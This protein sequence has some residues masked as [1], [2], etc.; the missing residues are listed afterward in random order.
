[1]SSG[2]S[3]ITESIDRETTQKVAA[4]PAS[5]DQESE[6]TTT[7]PI[8]SIHSGSTTESIHHETQEVAAECVLVA[9]EDQESRETTQGPIVSSGSN[10]TTESTDD[11]TAQEVFAEPVLVASEEQESQAATT[12]PIASSHSSCISESIDHETTR[13]LSAEPVVVA[14]EDEESRVTTQ[15]LA[16]S[17][18][19]SSTT[20]SIYHET[21]QEAVVEPVLVTSDDQESQETTTGPIASSHSSSF[22]DS[23]DHKTREVL[24]KPVLVASN[25]EES[26][27]TTPGPIASSHSST[28]TE[29]RDVVAREV[30]AEPV[31]VPSKDQESQEMTSGPIA[32]SQ[33][34][35]VEDVPVPDPSVDEEIQDATLADIDSNHSCSLESQESRG[36]APKSVPI[37]E[38]VAVTPQE[39]VET[40]TTPAQQTMQEVVLNSAASS[41]SVAPSSHE[42]FVAMPEPVPSEEIVAAVTHEHH[43]NE[44]GAVVDQARQEDMSGTSQDTLPTAKESDNAKINDEPD[45]L[46]DEKVSSRESIA[47]VCPESPEASGEAISQS[48]SIEVFF[49]EFYSTE[50]SSD[51]LDS[52]TVSSLE[53]PTVC[54]RTTISTKEDKIL[55]KAD[56]TCAP[57]DESAEE[58]RKS[59]HERHE[60]AETTDIW[61]FERAVEEFEA[62]I[63]A[64]LSRPSDEISENAK[65]QMQPHEPS[66][67]PLPRGRAMGVAAKSPA[68]P[69]EEPAMFRAMDPVISVGS[70][71]SNETGQEPS[72]MSAMATMSTLSAETAKEQPVMSAMG[73]R[74]T[75]QPPPSMILKPAP[76]STPPRPT[77]AV[78]SKVPLPKIISPEGSTI[79]NA[80]SSSSIL[81]T[82]QE[83]MHQTAESM[84][85]VEQ[86]IKRTTQTLFVSGAAALSVCSSE[87]GTEKRQPS[88]DEDEVSSIVVRDGDEPAA[89]CAPQSG[90]ITDSII[91]ASKEIDKLIKFRPCQSYV[92]KQAEYERKTH[93]L[94]TEAKIKKAEKHLIARLDD[95]M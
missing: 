53:N 34:V 73:S 86:S 35:A 93:G 31:L 16:V 52:S 15:R 2:S 65:P 27:E 63:F 11:E 47:V 89:T 1:V 58:R 17:S 7:G 40:T 14:S 84:E 4:G 12:E 44:T 62:G 82:A 92:M 74:Y 50:G 38:N 41:P 87:L 54:T 95:Y 10:S 72:V 46:S 64:V 68:T 43:C 71:M 39:A 57:A 28:T 77:R 30:V 90:A 8:A 51:Y 66:E 60:V 19:S 13:D 23:I 81:D 25:D 67:D 26:Q 3:F 45:E 88:A 18:D 24:A 80:L 79:E 49:K 6:P 91:K 61:A 83:V 78:P 85:A 33:E 37:S 76:R 29:S 42:G 22:A 75:Y 36:I 69:K 20:E 5:E 21:T 94:W 70:T 9:S 32:S 59:V 56:D 55:S 48:E